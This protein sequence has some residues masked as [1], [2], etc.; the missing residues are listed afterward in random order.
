MSQTTFTTTATATYAVGN[1]VAVTSTA[2]MFSGLPIVFTGTTFGGITAGATYY[3]GDIVV[4]YPSS[5][6]TLTTLPGGS[7]YGVD[8]GTG[9]MTATFNQG[10]Q[11]IIPTVAPGEP[12]NQSFI[13]II[14]FL[15]LL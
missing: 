1:T 15:L 7:T 8:N 10:G 9:N 13:L 12:L 6:I 2:N 11:Q 4:G 3:I 14:S 5:N